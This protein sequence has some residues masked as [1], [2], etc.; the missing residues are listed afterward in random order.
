[1]QRKVVLLLLVCWF[2]GLNTFLYAYEEDD[3][4]EDPGYIESIPIDDWDGFIP[5]LYSLGDQ[6]FTI[7]IGTV[8][9]LLFIGRNESG[10]LRREPDHNF[11]PPVGGSGS[12]SYNFFFNANF[13]VG[14]EIGFTFNATLQNHMVYFIP[15]GLRTGWQFVIRRLEI[16]LYTVFGIAPINYNTLSYT[17]IFLRGGA[18]IYYRFTPDWSFGLNT[19]WNWYP[20][21]PLDDDRKPD[22][23]KN[24]DANILGLTISARYHF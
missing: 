20:Q 8:F 4:E 6:T 2:C 22:R 18:G 5:D 9:P 7:T 15:I 10:D 23:A 17:G 12:L 3:E 19:D 24:V 16:P 13:F 14:G 1:M 11:T 21:R